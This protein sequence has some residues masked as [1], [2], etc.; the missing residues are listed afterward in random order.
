MTV[1]AQPSMSVIFLPHFDIVCDLLLNRPTTTENLFVYK[2][3]R[4]NVVDG[5]YLIKKQNVFNGNDI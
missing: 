1:G 4:Q 5:N 2:I 3:K